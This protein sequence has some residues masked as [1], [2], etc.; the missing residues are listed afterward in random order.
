MSFATRRLNLTRKQRAQYNTAL[1]NLR[2]LPAPTK[3]TFREDVDRAIAA[4]SGI[5]WSVYTLIDDEIGEGV[6]QHP[7][8]RLLRTIRNTPELGKRM[9]ATFTR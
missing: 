3:E 6:H 2:D 5:E 1:A 7:A 8:F 4:V 9:F